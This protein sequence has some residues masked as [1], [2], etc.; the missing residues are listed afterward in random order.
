MVN[1]WAVIS[2]DEGESIR[3]RIAD[4]FWDRFRGLIG[5]DPPPRGE[6]LLIRPCNSIH[7]FFMRFAIDVIF[8]DGE[9][10]VVKL[11]RDLSPG[12]IVNAV[13]GATQVVEVTAGSLPHSCRSGSQLTERR[14]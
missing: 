7:M 2:T 12:R 5:S 3:C 9:L 6:G 11:I 10:N 1:K 14:L 8:L 4:T 13:P